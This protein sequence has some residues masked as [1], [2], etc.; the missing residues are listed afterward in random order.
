[1]EIGTKYFNTLCLSLPSR[2]RKKSKSP[3]TEA[4]NEE[5]EMPLLCSY[6]DFLSHPKTQNSENVENESF[7]DGEEEE[8]WMIERLEKKIV[9]AAGLR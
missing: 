7:N 9:F 5:K 3:V 4:K 2:E 8:N 6:S 1:M